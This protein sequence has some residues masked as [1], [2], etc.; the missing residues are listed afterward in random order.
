MVG[1]EIFAPV[2]ESMVVDYSVYKLLQSSGKF[3]RN[4][5]PIPLISI[6]YV[7]YR[8][9]DYQSVSRTVRQRRW[10]VCQRKGFAIRRFFS[11]NVA[12]EPLRVT[13]P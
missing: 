12:R 5:G 8:P 7:S 6:K 3:F 13:S 2:S 10:D 4:F 1:V 9:C 11:E